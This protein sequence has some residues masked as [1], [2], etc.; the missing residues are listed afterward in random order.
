MP[1]KEWTHLVLEHE[2]STALPERHMFGISG[3]ILLIREE[4]Q[5]GEA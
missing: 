4:A 5:K 1:H 3:R 2:E